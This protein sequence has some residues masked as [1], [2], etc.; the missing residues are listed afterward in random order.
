MAA[1]LNHVNDLLVAVG[2][3]EAPDFQGIASRKAVLSWQKAIRFVSNTMR[4]RHLR[5]QVNP[6]SWVGFNVAIV[7]SY[8]SI[9]G[10]YLDDASPSTGTTKLYRR[11]FQQVWLRRNLTPSFPCSWSERTETSI[12]MDP[13]ATSVRSR[14]LV[15]LI[16]TPT[17]PLLVSDVLTQPENFLQCCELYAEAEMHRI[18]TTDGAAYQQALAAFE[19]QLQLERSREGSDLP[20]YW[21]M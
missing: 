9:I 2:E 4:W 6:A 18:H 1:F 14:I 3:L 19:Q 15:D 10:V 16:L 12:I 8:Q 11:E 20:S 17:V 5:S 13:V 21:R 7:P